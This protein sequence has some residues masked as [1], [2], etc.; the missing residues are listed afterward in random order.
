MPCGA[1]VPWQTAVSLARTARFAA[2]NGIPLDLCV[3]AG[4]SVVSE[5]RN[6]VLNSFFRTKADI[7]LWIDSDIEWS[8]ADFVRIVQHATLVDVVCAAYPVK[9]P[10]APFI[11]KQPDP[12][13][14][15]INGLGLVKITGIGLGFCAVRR[16]VL[17]ILA[18]TAWR[19]DIGDERDVADVFRIDRTVTNGRRVA[20]GEDIAFFDDVTAMGRDVWLDPTIE[21]GHVGNCVYR[22]DPVSAL[23]LDD[24]YRTKETDH[25]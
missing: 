2:Q 24:Y 6:L 7:L 11:I 14:V 13:D 17:E 22:G 25:V 5:A 10:G 4:G 1:N 8:V 19:V 3:T 12:D 18:S 20:R 23:H 21:L 9:T 16:S 15:E